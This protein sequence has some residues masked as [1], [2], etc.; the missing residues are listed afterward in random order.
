MICLRHSE[1][2]R[3]CVSICANQST[4]DPIYLQ[5][6]PAESLKQLAANLLAF[7]ATMAIGKG[8]ARLVLQNACCTQYC[9]WACLS[10][11]GRAGSTSSMF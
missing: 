6:D 10:E 8:K 4:S 3:Q 5:C 7:A 11:V 9:S 2:F 1:L